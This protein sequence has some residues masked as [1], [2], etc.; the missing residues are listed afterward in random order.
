MAFSLKVGEIPWQPPPHPSTGGNFFAWC[1]IS[2]NNIRQVDACSRNKHWT[3][4]YSYKFR[5]YLQPSFLKQQVR[6]PVFYHVQMFNCSN[7]LMDL[8]NWTDPAVAA[9]A[10]SADDTPSTPR[11]RLG[12]PHLVSVSRSQRQLTVRAASAVSAA[13]SL[14]IEKMSDVVRLDTSRGNHT[15]ILWALV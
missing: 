15:G 14:Q 3:D 12:I 10:S 6:R 4:A 13:K 8:C 2:E 1:L 7:V 5:R 9:A 11:R